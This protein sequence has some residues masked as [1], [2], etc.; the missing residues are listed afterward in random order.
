MKLCRYFAVLVLVAAL[1]VPG[2]VFARKVRIPS[3]PS[4]TSSAYQNK[5]IAPGATVWACAYGG[6]T[7]IL[8]QLWEAG[9]T[10]AARHLQVVD[11]RLPSIV[12]DILNHPERLRGRVSIPLHTDPIE[13]Q[14][15]GQLAEAV[16]CGDNK[17][18]GVL[19]A[20]SLLELSVLVE[21]FEMARQSSASSRQ[22][23]AELLAEV[24]R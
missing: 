21:K 22:D 24:E 8:C 6:N 13:F 23:N 5:P 11:P 16:M 2:S 12:R 1:L 18:C 17:S 20:K 3:L 19:F 4:D 7:R 15:V 10:V 9:S 14:L